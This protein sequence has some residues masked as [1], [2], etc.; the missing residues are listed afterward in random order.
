[1]RKLVFAALAGVFMLSSGFSSIEKN[2]LIS[3]GNAFE[4]C[5]CHSI[6]FY[7]DAQGD[8][9]AQTLITYTSTRGA[10]QLFSGS[11]DFDSFAWD[12][13][14]CKTSELNQRPDKSISK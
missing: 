5:A 9:R 13:L 12:Y 10:C 4:L 3:F 1:M 2:E 7:Y 8:L 6:N 14:T 11:G